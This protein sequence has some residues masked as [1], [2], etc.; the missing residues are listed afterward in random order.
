MAL[1]IQRAEGRLEITGD[2]G[3]ERQRHCIAPHIAVVVGLAFFVRRVQAVAEHA[4]R[5][6][7]STEIRVLGPHAVG[8]VADVDAAY[9]GGQDRRLFRH[10]V[11]HAARCAEAV[12]ETRQPLQQFHFFEL[13]VRHRDA[14]AVKGHAVDLE[15]RLPVE[16]HAAHRHVGGP[17]V[18]C[19]AVVGYRGIS[20]EDIAKFGR[21]AILQFF[22]G[23]HGRGERRVELRARAECP[24]AD[25]F[26]QMLCRVLRRR[27]LDRRQRFFACVRRRLND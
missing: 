27:D 17:G 12:H 5:A 3:V 22:A 13:L 10:V 1:L 24:A 9:R 19:V 8:V 2:A 21:L 6:D 23:D 25:A 18:V 4:V 20:G 7:A 26:L 14:I 11:D 16:L 15:A